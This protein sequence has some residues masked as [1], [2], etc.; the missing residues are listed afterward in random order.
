[1]ALLPHLT[2]RA[3]QLCDGHRPKAEDLVQDVLVR[4]LESP[5]R[6]REG[7]K[8]KHWLR[9]VMRYMAIDRWKDSPHDE[10]TTPLTMPGERELQFE[11]QDQED[12]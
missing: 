12:W 3:L 4:W 7:V 2:A 9:T 5:P 6:A 1:V 10:N 11:L 8:L